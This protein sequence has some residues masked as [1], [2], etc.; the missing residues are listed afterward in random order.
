MACPTSKEQFA[1]LAV[2]CKITAFRA[3]SAVSP[4]S[5]GSPTPC[6]LPSGVS[7]QPEATA[8]TSAFRN[9]GQK[10]DG[11][12]PTQRLKKRRTDVMVHK[13]CE[14]NKRR[15]LCKLCHGGGGSICEHGKQRQWCL[16]CKPWGTGARCI[17]GKQKSKCVACGGSGIC[18]HDMVRGKCPTCKFMNK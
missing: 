15:N 8:R 3:V 11:D 18:E 16:V 9:I 14:H 13:I 12:E 7:D 4:S 6:A 5:E 17:H 10:M 2:L 1:P